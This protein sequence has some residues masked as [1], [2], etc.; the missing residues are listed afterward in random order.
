MPRHSSERVRLIGVRLI[1][2]RLCGQ[3]DIGQVGDPP[4][5]SLPLVSRKN[6]EYVVVVTC[7]TANS[8]E[9]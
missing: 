1:V 3:G 6:I 5:I 7:T 9:N 4:E 2:V 8:C